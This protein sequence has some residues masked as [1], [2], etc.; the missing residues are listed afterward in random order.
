MPTSRERLSYLCNK[1]NTAWSIDFHTH[2]NAHLPYCF[3]CKQPYDAV[4]MALNLS[5]QCD[6]PQIHEAIAEVTEM[7]YGSH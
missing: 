5:P 6:C 3:F 2:L 4:E 1:Y 7:T